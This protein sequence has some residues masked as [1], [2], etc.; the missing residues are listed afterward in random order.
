MPSPRIRA[1]G[2]PPILVQEPL[3]EAKLAAPYLRPE[4][5]PR[6]SLLPRLL[7]ADSGLVTSSRRRVRQV[8]QPR[9]VAGE[10]AA[11]GGL[12]HRATRPT[13]TRS[14]SSTTSAL[15]IERA[16]GRGSRSWSG[17]ARTA[18]SALSNAVP[19]LTSALH[20]LGRPMVLMLDDVHHLGGT[21]SADVLAMVVDYLPRGITIAAAGRTD[22]GLPLARLRASGRLVE[23]GIGD[24]ALDEA[25]AGRMAALGG[26]QLPPGRGP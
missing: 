2:P 23:I 14:G 17:S 11:A 24:L 13:P 5:L 6:D 15:A 7:G 21:P 9:A 16:L 10:G 4:V 26:R 1:P 12:G 20:E 18:G 25:E 19:R 22:A 8:H 3:V